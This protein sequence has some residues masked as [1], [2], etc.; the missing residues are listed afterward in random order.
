MSE[1][2]E[3]AQTFLDISGTEMFI[4]KTGVVEG[5]P[6]DKN[7]K[8]LHD[9]YSVRLVRGDQSYKFTFYDSAYNH[10]KG[11]RPSK[12][13]ILAS[14]QKYPVDDNMWTFTEESGYEIHCEED[15]KR[16]KTVWQ[17]CKKEYKSLLKMYG[18]Y[19]MDRLSEIW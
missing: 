13:D 17:N 11:K 16:A 1:Y 14:L 5:F 15:Y 9:K 19:F 12:Y 18:P 2:D 6:F 7:D 8:L 3:Q 10:E 4:R